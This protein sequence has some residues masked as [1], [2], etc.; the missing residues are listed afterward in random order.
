MKRFWLGFLAG[1]VATI[2]ALYTWDLLDEWADASR[3]RWGD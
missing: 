3:R 1:S 2:A